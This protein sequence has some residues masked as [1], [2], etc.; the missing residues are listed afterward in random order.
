MDTSLHST[1]DMTADS[2]PDITVNIAPDIVD[3]LTRIQERSIILRHAQGE[4]PEGLNLAE[5][6][7][8]HWIG[9]LPGANVTRIAAQMGMTRGAISKIAKRLLAKGLAESRRMPGN[10]KE[11]HFRLTDSGARVFDEHAQCHAAA[12]DEKLALLAGFTM[13]EQ[14]AVLRF[15]SAV[16]ARQQ[17]Q[18]QREQR[19]TKDAAGDAPDETAAGPAE[20]AAGQED[21]HV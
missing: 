16:G 15:L 17:A 7:C 18:M 10:N 19:V 14:R 21:S 13:D 20:G 9:A 8:I 11:L 6:H 2:A 1:P 5:T 3:A 12:R 4:V